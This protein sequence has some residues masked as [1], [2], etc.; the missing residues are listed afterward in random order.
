MLGVVLGLER[1]HQ[2]TYA[3]AVTVETDHQPLEAIVRKP[4]HLAPGEALASINGISYY[5]PLQ[6]GAELYTADALSRAAL[7]DDSTENGTG[8]HQ[9][10]LEEV[11]LINM[12]DLLPISDT[13]IAEIQRRYSSG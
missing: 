7:P 8:D 5:N 9:Q 3:N 1:F 12:V 2:Y 4:L 13:K 11:A 6:K 10:F